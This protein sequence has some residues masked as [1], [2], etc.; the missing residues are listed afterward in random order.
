MER[1]NAHGVCTHKYHDSTNH[2]GYKSRLDQLQSPD[3]RPQ[4]NGYQ[5]IAKHLIPLEIIHC[6]HK[7]KKPSPEYFIIEKPLLKC[8]TFPII[9]FKKTDER[10]NVIDWYLIERFGLQVTDSSTTWIRSSSKIACHP[11]PTGSLV[12]GWYFSAVALF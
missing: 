1:N 12:W 8:P 7:W 9:R 5:N 6:L 2:S 3:I 11:R 10:F 4:T